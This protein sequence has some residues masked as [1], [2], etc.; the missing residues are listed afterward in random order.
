MTISQPFQYQ[1]S[2]RGFAPLVMQSLPS[3]FPMIMPVLEHRNEQS[4]PIASPAMVPSTYAP[5]LA[6]LKV[7]VF[8]L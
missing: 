8:T 3:K 7:R 2:K 6:D 5:L 1:G 4:E